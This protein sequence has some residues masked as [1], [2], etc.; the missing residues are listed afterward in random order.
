M[1][2]L[3]HRKKLM[4]INLKDIYFAHSIIKED[5]GY[6]VVYYFH[7]NEQGPDSTIFNTIFIDLKQSEEEI[8]NQ[9]NK[10]NRSLIKKLFKNNDFNIAITDC[11]TETEIEE[12]VEFYDMF[13]KKK[14]I[15][16]ADKKLLYRLNDIS[17]L[18]IGK[19]YHEGDLLSS[20]VFIKN[21]ERVTGQY[22]GS[23][24][25]FFP[26][27]PHKVKMASKANRILEYMCMLHFKKEGLKIYDLGGVTLDPNDIEK[28]NIDMRKK[29]FGGELVKEYHFMY[30]LTL[31]GKIFIYLKKFSE[32]LRRNSK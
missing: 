26:E 16:R 28:A 14:G 27:N 20:M 30:P 18:S 15:N 23:G 31:K 25:F 7:C 21:K 13:A 19:A 4:A 6:D 12:F 10:T 29:G 1:I 22:E 5:P 17:S 2:E 32:K 8:L 3:N 11:P 24:R 9:F